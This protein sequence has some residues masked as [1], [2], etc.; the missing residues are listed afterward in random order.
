M[1]FI[2]WFPG[3]CARPAGDKGKSVV[4]TKLGSARRSCAAAEGDDQPDLRKAYSTRPGRK[5]TRKLKKVLRA[6]KLIRAVGGCAPGSARKK[7]KLRPGRSG[8]SSSHRRIDQIAKRASGMSTSPRGWH[9]PLIRAARVN[10]GLVRT[11][12]IAS[13]PSTSNRRHDLILFCRRRLPDPRRIK[14]S[15][16][17]RFHLRILTPEPPRSPKPRLHEMKIL[18]IRFARD[19]IRILWRVR[20]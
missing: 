10:N 13:A 4:M 11:D 6:W 19:G 7:L 14:A 1:L 15:I 20:R 16:Q 18:A 2:S 3:A 8:S 5:R 12:P 9:R 17:N